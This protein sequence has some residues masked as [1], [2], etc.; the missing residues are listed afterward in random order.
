MTPLQAI[1][2]TLGFM[3][4]AI[5]AVFFWLGSASYLDAFISPLA[6]LIIGSVL[7]VLSLIGL[8]LLSLKVNHG[9]ANDKHEGSVCQ[10]SKTKKQS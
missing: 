1:L 6:A 3:I 5:T 2:A 9:F 8:F 4:M 7:A 10:K